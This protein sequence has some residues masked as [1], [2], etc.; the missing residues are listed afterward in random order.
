MQNAITLL[1][2]TALIYK[3]QFDFIASN[4]LDQSANVDNNKPN[5]TKKKVCTVYSELS[6]FFL[7]F[8]NTPILYTLKLILLH[9]KK[10]KYSNLN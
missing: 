6:G 10:S 3:A 8:K 4:H 1:S 7:R 2:M 9:E 5:K